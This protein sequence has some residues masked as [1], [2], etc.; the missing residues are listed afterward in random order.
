M[1]AAVRREKEGHLSLHVAL[2]RPEASALAPDSRPYDGAR[3][4][5]LELRPPSERGTQKQEAADERRA[6]AQ[7]RCRRSTRRADRFSGRLDARIMAAKRPKDSLSWQN[8]GWQW[9]S[10][11]SRCANHICLQLV[12]VERRKVTYIVHAT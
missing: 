6:G 3:C 2:N 12:T 1:P 10:G 11:K 7:Y 9:L 4:T 5:P 8:V